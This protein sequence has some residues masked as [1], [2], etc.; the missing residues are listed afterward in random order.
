MA[1]SGDAP[2]TL[3]TIASQGNP[4]LRRP[5]KE[6]VRGP[7]V[8]LALLKDTLPTRSLQ[9]FMATARAVLNAGLLER[10]ERL[11]AR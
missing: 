1:A 11:A 6:S 4:V 2:E 3:Q 10:Y 8:C 7:K 5:L 9:A